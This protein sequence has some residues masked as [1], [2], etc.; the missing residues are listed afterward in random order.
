MVVHQRGNEPALIL[1]RSR[2]P[3]ADWDW[4]PKRPVL[5]DQD[6]GGLIEEMFK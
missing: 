5:E 1:W 6:S 3:W 4:E 2:E